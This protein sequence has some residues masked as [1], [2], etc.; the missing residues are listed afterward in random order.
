MLHEIM[1]YRPDH[2]EIQKLEP[3]SFLGA[4]TSSFI[5]QVLRIH[6]HFDERINTA[7]NDVAGALARAHDIGVGA[8]QGQ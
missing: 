4:S 1:Y 5:R 8:L 6:G 2:L 7:R 3:L